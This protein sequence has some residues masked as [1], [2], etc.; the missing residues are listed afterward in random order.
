MPSKRIVVLTQYFPPEMGAPQVRLSELGRELASRDW[1]VTVLTALPNYPTGRVFEG[2][3]PWR[4]TEESSG[5]LR[6]VRVPLWPSKH[7]AVRRLAT[8]GSFAASASFF[9]KRRIDDADLL[10]VESPPIFLG[11]AARK[12]ARRWQCPYI[13]NVSDLWPDSLLHVG[14]MRRDFKYRALQ[15]IERRLYEGATGFTG[16]SQE[17]V[18]AVQSRTQ[19]K[20]ALVVTNGVDPSR[21]GPDH[22]TDRARDL[23]GSEPGPIFVYA[24]LF[25]IAQGL[26]RILDLAQRL[27]ESTPGRF[28]LVGDG[29]EREAIERRVGAENIDRVRVLPALPRDEIPALLAVSDAAIIPLVTKLPGAVPSKIYEA[30]ASRLPILLV[31]EGEAAERVEVARAGIAVA[32]GASRP[33][34]DAFLRLASNAELREHLGR[35][36]RVAAESQYA[37][38]EIAE[39]L[40]HFLTEFVE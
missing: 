4:V 8:Y 36:G 40:D 3:S 11:R 29:P 22:A 17:I 9:G 23:V 37:R 16:Q 26:D 32:P 34:R 2:Y 38:H 13:L 20:P 14:A 6:V 19:D 1:D 12:L 35:A 24:G 31:A 18:S 39:R 27:P 5:P 28:V 33:L 25:G 30:M 15:R 7:G 10:F 21:F